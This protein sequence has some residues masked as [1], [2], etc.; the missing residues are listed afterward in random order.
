MRTGLCLSLF[1]DGVSKLNSI[2]QLSTF[3]LDWCTVL[4]GLEG[5]GIG[6]I[7]SFVN[8]GDWHLSD[9]CMELMLFTDS[10]VPSP[11]S[12]VWYSRYNVGVEEE[13]WDILIFDGCILLYS[14]KDMQELVIRSSVSSLGLNSLFDAS[15]LFTWKW[16]KIVNLTMTVVPFSSKYLIFF[17]G[18][19]SLLEI[20]FPTIFLFSPVLPWQSMIES[21]AS[22]TY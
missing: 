17:A 15:F 18:I 7:V 10:E 11:V 5:R 22:L 13:I 6:W 9:S 19:K 8:F 2:M 1:I 4:S 16:F 3:S 20:H 14:K 12:F 21:G